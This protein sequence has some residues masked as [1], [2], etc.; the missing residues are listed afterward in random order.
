VD[1]FVCVK[2]A[3]ASRKGV[4]ASWKSAYV[5]LVC[6]GL[7]GFSLSLGLFKIFSQAHLSKL[8]LIE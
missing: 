6:F 3:Y 7:L 8:F 2:V 1:H 5:H 4:Y